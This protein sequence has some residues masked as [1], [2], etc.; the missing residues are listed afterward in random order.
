MRLLRRHSFII[1]II[2]VV[3]VIVVVGHLKSFL[4]QKQQ[5][6]SFENNT[7]LRDRRTD[8]QMDGHNLLQ[9]CVV[10]SKNGIT[11][12]LLNNIQDLNHV[13]LLL[14][15]FMPFLS[16][17]FIYKRFCFCSLLKRSKFSSTQNSGAQNF[18][19]QISHA[20]ILALRSLAPF[21]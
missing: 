10:A 15:P 3:V 8:G 19:A 6:L 14:S 17:I 2:I 18:G 4:P 11:R 16:F 5:I 7:G 21:L 9:R 1:I 20:Q 12:K 13:H